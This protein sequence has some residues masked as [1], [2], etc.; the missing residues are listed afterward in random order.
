MHEHFLGFWAVT[1]TDGETLL[2]TLQSIFNEVGIS[3]TM[4][5]AQ[6]YDGAANMKGRYSGLATR[7]KGIEKRA[8]YIHCYA[9][10]LNLTLQ[11]ACQSIKEVRN[12]I[13]TVNSAKRHGK[14]Q[15]VRER[16]CDSEST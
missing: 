1:S 9:H 15:D 3:M 6:C 12:V 10:L 4:L 16:A 7:I 11:T 5:R 2:S 13:G 14:F 8:V